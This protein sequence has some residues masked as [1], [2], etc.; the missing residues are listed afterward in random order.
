MGKIRPR[1]F[2]RTT[3][4]SILLAS[5]SLLILCGCSTIQI[6]LGWKV[7]LAKTDISTLQASQYKHPGIGPGEKSS[8]IVEFTQPDGKLLLTQGK[9]K[10]KVLWSDLAITATVVSV[11][12][13]GVLSLPADPRLSDG[14]TGHITITV[15]SH[16]GLHADLDIPLRYNYKFAADYSGSNGSSGTNGL[17]GSD[18]SSGSPGSIDPNNPSPGGNGGDGSS[19]ANGGDG[20]NGGDALPVQ[21]QVALQPGAH[22]LL[23][24]GVTAKGRKESF[25]LVDP[26]GGSLTISAVGGSGGSGGTG[27][28][29]GSGGSGGSGTPNG[30][31]GSSGSDGHDGSSGSSGRSATITVTYDPQA[32]PYLAAILTQNQG[33]PAPTFTRS[34]VPPLW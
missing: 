22:P 1:T 2:R 24:I 8:L 10:G 29:G 31:N 6:K 9:G 16:P 4:N 14:K 15:P 33:A 32:K 23:Q 18:G 26:Q 13:K 30:S 28:K 21:V 3:K 25:Y 19:G 27:G 11:N 34:P 7:S 17:A 20:G 5:A 12:K